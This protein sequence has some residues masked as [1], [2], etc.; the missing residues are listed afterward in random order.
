MARLVVSRQEILQWIAEELAKREECS[1]C[2]A[3]SIGKISPP[4]S[5]GCNWS[6]QYFRVTGV[7]AESCMTTCRPVMDKIIL[8]AQAKFNIE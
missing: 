1:Q 5:D 7:P 6:V 3:P 8:R 4:D 2:K